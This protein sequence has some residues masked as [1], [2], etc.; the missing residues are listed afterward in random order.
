MRRLDTGSPQ[1]C[2]R[3]RILGGVLG[4]RASGI[5]QCRADGHLAERLRQIISRRP[6][7]PRLAAHSISF[8]YSENGTER[9]SEIRFHSRYGEVSPA[10]ISR[11]ICVPSGR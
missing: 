1:D 8:T 3:L 10:N 9:A 4:L 7:F 5:G 11:L 6:R 2:G